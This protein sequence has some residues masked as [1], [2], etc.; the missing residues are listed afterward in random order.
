MQARKGVSGGRGR[1]RDGFCV[2]G[3]VVPMKTTP[4]WS[5]G[6]SIVRLLVALLVVAAL[7][8]Q[9][10]RSISNA[11]DRGS[12]EW[13]VTAN[14]FSFFTV[15]SNVFSVIVLVILG[16][17]GLTRRSAAPP[18]TPSTALTF[19]H[20]SVMTYM[21]VTGVVY[22][23]LLRGVALPQG[24]TVV[25]SNEVLHVVGPLFLLVD[26]IIGTWP[27]RLPWR[28]VL[29]ILVFPVLWIVY[30]LVRGPLVTNPVTGA[31]WWYP[32]PFLDPHVIGGYAGMVP[33]ILGIAV[34]LALFATGVVYVGRRRFS[35]ASAEPAVSPAGQVL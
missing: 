10:S 32:Y 28:A 2:G 26:L 31:A 12:G 35:G 34:G 27:P 16:I 9:L 19:A 13:T 25:W 23:T 18:S 3:Y 14:F 29:G 17:V 11:M 8:A 21:I 5:T 20:A 4:G 15:L 22:N 6:W 7:V 30:T 33:Y 24:T 1:T